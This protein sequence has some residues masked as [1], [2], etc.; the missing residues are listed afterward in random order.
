MAGAGDSKQTGHHHA[1]M[2]A[3]QHCGETAERSSSRA[4][5]PQH[6]RGLPLQVYDKAPVPK[7]RASNTMKVVQRS[8]WEK[9]MEEKPAMEA[10]MKTPVQ[11][12]VFY[13]DTCGSCKILEPK[14]E[15]A[16]QAVNM[17][18]I[19]VVKFDFS[20]K[21]TIEATKMLAAEFSLR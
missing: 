8:S 14:M 13:S 7:E 15:A 11:A 6:A 16:M 2:H 12:V 19:N 9:K 1:S 21:E 5:R 10:T 18:K 17:D 4:P 20:N 3:C